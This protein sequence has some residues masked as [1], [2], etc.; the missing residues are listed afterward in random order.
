MAYLAEKAG[1][2]ASDGRKRVLDIVP[3]RFLFLFLFS[4]FIYLFFFSFIAFTKDA[5]FSLEAKMMLKMLRN[6]TKR[7]M[8]TKCNKLKKIKN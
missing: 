1:G 3:K 2:K 5:L 4:S 7:W 6:F 8:K